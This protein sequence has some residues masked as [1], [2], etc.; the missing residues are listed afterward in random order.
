M[1]FVYYTITATTTMSDK[2]LSATFYSCYSVINYIKFYVQIVYYIEI[3]NIL[4]WKF[5]N[6]Y[7]PTV[8]CISLNFLFGQKSH[9]FVR[10]Y[11]ASSSLKKSFTSVGNCG[12]N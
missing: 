3:K 7:V 8:K 4:C 6:T 11:L 1:Y 2:K 9:L 5:I 10:I 12:I